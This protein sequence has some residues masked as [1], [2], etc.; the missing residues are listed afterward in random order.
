MWGGEIV[1]EDFFC[2]DESAAVG[3]WEEGTDV[4]KAVLAE[5][6]DDGAGVVLGEVG[7]DV[8]ESVAGF[9]VVV[10]V[11]SFSEFGCDCLASGDEALCCEFSGFEVRGFELFD[12]V[13]DGE[14]CGLCG[15]G[16]VG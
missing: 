16:F 8:F 13:R 15:G 7:E 14:H 6:G 10:G 5:L 12:E 1:G 2:G 3:E 4:L 11:E 9:V